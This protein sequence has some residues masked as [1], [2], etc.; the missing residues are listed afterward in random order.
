MTNLSKSFFVKIACL[1]FTASAMSQSAIFPIPQEVQ[2]NERIFKLDETASLIMPN[3]ASE[4]DMFLAK[5]LVREMSNNYGVALKIQRTDIIPKNRNVFLMGS[6]DNV[7]VS[8]YNAE[9]N[10]GLTEQ[11]PGPEGYILDVTEGIVFVGG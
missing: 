2:H 9:K 1:L 4:N 8:Q 5:S 7:L 11:K 10:L 3:N 6:L